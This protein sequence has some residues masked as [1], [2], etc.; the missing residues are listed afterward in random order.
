MSTSLILLDAAGVIAIHERVVMANEL[1]GMASDKSLEA[2]LER[3]HN[4]LQYGFIND[5]FDLAA[6]YG[7]FISKGHCFNDA[8][9]RTAAAAVFITL[10]LNGVEPKFRDVTLGDWIIDLVVDRQTED[11]F[12]EWLRGLS[13]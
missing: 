1:Q 5:L 12:A 11:V 7:T 3:V 10:Y 9:K 2:V 8:N 4:R 6:C 13:G